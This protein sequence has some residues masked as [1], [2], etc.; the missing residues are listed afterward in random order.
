MGEL[1]K[2][3]SGLKIVKIESSDINFAFWRK[4]LE[5][6]LGF[7]TDVE[8]YKVDFTPPALG[9]TLK[10]VKRNN[11]YKKDKVKEVLDS[12]KDAKEELSN[13]ISIN[14]LHSAY[15]VGETNQRFALFME[16]Q[17]AVIQQTSSNNYFVCFRG[18]NVL[19]S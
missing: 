15:F 1:I 18:C 5:S 14:F 16:K 19:S 10:D 4:P 17:G 13:F 3:N 7:E 8:M 11:Y 12:F 9:I 6:I 2:Y